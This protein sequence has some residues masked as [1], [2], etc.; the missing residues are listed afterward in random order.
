MPPREPTTAEEASETALLVPVPAAERV[1]GRW[2]DRLDPSCR[3]GMPAHITLLYPFVPPSRVDQTLVDE[4][5]GLLADAH[6]FEFELSSVRW[7]GED[8]VWAE[9]K[10]PEPFLGLTDLVLARWPSY[11]P[12][13][14]AH[15]EVVPHLT[16]A[17][18]CPPEDME[19][20]AAAVSG[21]LPIRSRAEEVWLMAGSRNPHSWEIRARFP[22]GA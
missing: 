22:L 9:P 13:Q 7:F 21:E 15:S 10:P 5:V 17:Q 16:I 6:R 3:L 20:A 18:D 8:V 11:P 1:V 14:G 2:R 19:E 4:L 12:Y